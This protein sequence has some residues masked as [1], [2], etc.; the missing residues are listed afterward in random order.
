MNKKNAFLLLF[1]SIFCGLSH[2]TEKRIVSAKSYDKLA[3][4]PQSDAPAT[5]VSLNDTDVAARI[6]A[7]VSAIDVRVAQRVKAGDVL[8]K[9]DCSDHELSMREAKAAINNNLARQELAEYQL[10]RAKKLQKQS[11]VSEELYRTRDSEMKALRAEGQSLVAAG[12]KAELAVERCHVRAPFDGVVMKR[13]VDVGEWVSIGTAVIQ[14]VDLSNIELSAEVVALQ[15]PEFINAGQYFFRVNGKDYPVDVRA[16]NPVTDTR[17]RTRNVRLL[18]KEEALSPGT[19]GR[20]LWKQ[21]Q[22]YLPPDVLV[23]RD[24]EIGVFVVREGKARFLSIPNAQEGRPALL[25]L[26]G[27]AQII[28]KGRFTVQD[29]DAVLIED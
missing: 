8:L 17:T 22:K 27:N 11:H 4:F 2:A 29:G 16:V 5:V 13:L 28:L 15:I 7:I 9:L 21:T 23:R 20:L 24:K 18:F 26:P 3:V 6:P 25:N 12:K 10:Q 1:L 19:T 14:M